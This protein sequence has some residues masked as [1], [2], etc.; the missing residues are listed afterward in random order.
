MQKCLL[1]AKLHLACVTAAD[2]AYEGSI[3]I[4]AALLD[5]AGIVPYEQVHVWDVTNGERLI[6]YAL[7]APAGSGCIA[8]NG[9]GALKMHRGDRVIIASFGWL[10][11]DEQIRHTPRQFLLSER[12]EIVRLL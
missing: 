6:T 2:P 7:A 11:P 12:N 9:A 10:A 4:D 8:I 5:R 3:A 1:L